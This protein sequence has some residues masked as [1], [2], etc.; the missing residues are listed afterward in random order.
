MNIDGNRSATNDAWGVA[1]DPSASEKKWLAACTLLDGKMP[2][3]AVTKRRLPQ[4]IGL[5]WS[6][7]VSG[8]SGLGAFMIFG[9]LSAAV[10]ESFTLLSGVFYTFNG[11][12]AFALLS[13]AFIAFSS[14]FT[15]QQHVWGGGRIWSGLHF[16]LVACGALLP[17][18]LELMFNA[19]HVASNLLFFSLWGASFIGLSVLST[20]MT[21]NS[22]RTL[23]KSIGANRV[24]PYSRAVFAS[25]GLV[26]LGLITV[27]ALSTAIS[28]T[29]LWL[30]VVLIG[31]GYY[32]TK[33][34]NARNPQTATT[35]ALASWNPLILANLVLL[36]AL[37]VNS[38]LSMFSLLPQI[39]FVDYLIGF[40]TMACLTIGPVLG[41]K[42]ASRGLQRSRELELHQIPAEL[43]NEC[44]MP[45]NRVDDVICES[46]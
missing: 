45:L 46:T 1:S 18:S 14:V 11:P 41:A 10:C 2:P 9:F 4:S 27:P 37:V 12:H 30:P 40:G 28:S 38:I 43:L 39:G 15:Y 7:C 31:S 33:L 17:F 19:P 26:L 21:N 22:I 24:M 32:I 20:R 36:P 5:P 34:N 42:I 13:A 29:W 23:E 35:M 8:I 44:K 16:G 3:S 25:A 6:L